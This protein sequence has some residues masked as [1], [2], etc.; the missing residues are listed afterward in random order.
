MG[1]G[2][3]IDDAAAIAALVSC[4]QVK[5]RKQADEVLLRKEHLSLTRPCLFLSCMF[6]AWI[7]NNQLKDYC[8]FGRTSTEMSV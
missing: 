3:Y 6:L 7:A 2:G 5:H 4:I 1:I 8:A